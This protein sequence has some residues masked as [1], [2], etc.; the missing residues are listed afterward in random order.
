MRNLTLKAHLISVCQRSSVV[1]LLIWAGYPAHARTRDVDDVS[2]LLE[3]EHGL[4]H[5][6]ADF[7]IGFGVGVVGRFRG[8]G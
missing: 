5:G 8:C 3:F 6:F 7:E 1:L 2:F 4:A